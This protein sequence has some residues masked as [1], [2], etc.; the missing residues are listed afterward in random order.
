MKSF[1]EISLPIT[2][3]EYRADGA[4]H[5][6]TLA[7]FK[8]GGFHCLDTLFD[9]KETTSLLFGSIVDTLMTDGQEAFDSQYFVSELPEISDQIANVVKGLFGVYKETCASLD[10]VPDAAI[11]GALDAIDYGKSWYANTR[12]KK[13][14]EP[15]TAYYEQMYLAGDRI[16]I[17]NEMY[18]DACNCVDALR[19][20]QATAQL[21]APNN[22]FE[23]DI[24][25]C[26][27]LK[28][29]NIF[30]EIRYSCMADLIYVDHKKKIVIPCDLKTSSHYEDEFYKSFVDWDYMI[31]ARLY[32]RLI[33]AAMDADDYFK[34]FTLLDY[35][36]I[37]V[38]KK[39]LVPL[40]WKYP[41]TQKVGT[42]YYGKNKQIE[43]PDPFEIGKELN[44]YL[45]ARPSV[46]I[47]ISIAKPNDL[48]LFLN[49]M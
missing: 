2:E 39:S 43:C 21:F 31:Q 19:T 20:S 49:K 22:P 18:A 1:K 24:E 32:W 41:D 36:F 34:D 28:F 13:V 48:N 38:N 26:Y 4:M 33:R 23:P 7:S 37:V 47:G 3:A 16:L 40:V 27:Q 17:S 14:R 9:K 44:T 5:Y 30:E 29:S 6:S 45:T 12:I 15:G 42:L 25:R 8:R 35:H 10:K 46:P 11:L